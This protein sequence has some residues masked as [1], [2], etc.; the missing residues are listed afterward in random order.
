M[1]ETR[2]PA[3]DSQRADVSADERPSRAE[4][5]GRI[6]DL[7]AENARL[8]E[9]YRRARRSQYRRSALALAGLGLTAGL[10]SI[11]A[12]DERSVLL[13]LA[14]I[15]LFSGVLVYYLTP[16]R[17]VPESV[18]QTTFATYGENLAAIR[19]EL[20]LSDEAIYVPRPDR[21][22]VRVFLPQDSAPSIPTEDAL[23]DT[24]VV[25]ETP[26][27][28]GVALEPVG[29]GLVVEYEDARTQSAS[30]DAEEIATGLADSLVEV[31]E[32]VDAAR[33]TTG[34]SNVTVTIEGGLAES[35]F[36]L[37]HPIPSYL[38][39]ALAS[40]VGDPIEVNVTQDGES[41]H[42]VCSIRK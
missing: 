33:I 30:G 10:L 28:R 13:A 19:G 17:L 38:G 12:T 15:G 23:D 42:V 41:V 27:E 32:V 9:D 37:E 36:G 29:A 8:R 7:Q 35:G 2:Q 20:G 6:D 24:F 16:E 39:T 11:V 1:S 25:G 21:G 14:G 18:L 22:D 31:F 26:R 4:L 5:Q 3:S 40:E 34:E